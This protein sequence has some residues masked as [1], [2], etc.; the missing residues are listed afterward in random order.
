M[1]NKA[2]FIAVAAVI[3]AF[4]PTASATIQ[5]T[6]SS[7]GTT[8]TVNDTNLS[9]D[10][11]G[12][13]G[14]ITYSGA[15]GNWN[16]NVTTGTVGTNPLID[17]SSIDQLAGLGTGVNALTLEFSGTGFSGPVAF[18]SANIGGT[19]ATGQSLTYKAYKDSGNA[20]NALT[21]QIGSTLAFGPDGAFSGATFGSSAGAGLF[22]LTQVVVM[23][24]TQNGRSSFDANINAGVPEPASVA[25]L[26]GVLLFAVAAIRRRVRRAA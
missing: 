13:T 19:L 16:L 2:W 26:G 17:L 23:S 12:L 15:V 22:S 8:V 21:T 1:R 14:C 3:L 24:G 10:V 7:G 4:A 9:P 25:L 20:L 11:C 18:F 6:L 5:L